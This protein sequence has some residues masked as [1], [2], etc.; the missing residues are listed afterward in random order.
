MFNLAAANRH[1]AVTHG[2]Y[3]KI[4]DENDST[5]IDFECGWLDAQGNFVSLGVDHVTIGGEEREAFLTGLSAV[6]GIS[7]TRVGAIE[8]WL[9]GKLAA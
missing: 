6:I 1:P 2:R 5:S 8:A 4:V 7:E 3:K 9:E